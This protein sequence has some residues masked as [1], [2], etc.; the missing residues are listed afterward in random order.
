MK[1]TLGKLF[2]RWTLG[3]LLFIGVYA[4]FFPSREVD[5]SEVQFSTPSSNRLYFKN[6]RAYFY[7]KE[8]LEKQKIDI[9]RMKT[10]NTEDSL[11]I[12]S[13]AIVDHWAVNRSYIIAETSLL[14][15]NDQ[16]LKIKC[17]H[18]SDAI[19][20]EL[21]A[22]DAEAN[23]KFAAQLLTHLSHPNKLFVLEKHKGWIPLKNSHKK[24]FKRS[25]L[26][27]FKLVGKL[28]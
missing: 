12:L 24:K 16:A 20:I 10:S 26:D 18:L 8:E 6:I 28:H 27:Y 2:F 9:Y 11:S 1:S 22:E 19:F 7:E 21:K 17:E 23:Y 14:N 25:L 3:M 5:L 15:V 13:F 4:F